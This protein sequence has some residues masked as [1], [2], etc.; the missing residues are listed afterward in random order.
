[1]TEDQRKLVK[2][3]RI[4]RDTSLD[5]FTDE[6]VFEVCKDTLGWSTMVCDNELRRLYKI[7][8]EEFEKSAGGAAIR[9][10]QRLFVK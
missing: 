8:G 7:V 2:Q 3:Y 9:K 4:M 1:M 5:A 6:Q 10:L